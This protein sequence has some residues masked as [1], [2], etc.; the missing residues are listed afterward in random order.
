MKDAKKQ[1]VVVEEKQLKPVEKMPSKTDDGYLMF[2]SEK[3][4]AK[5]SQKLREMNGQQ[6]ELEKVLSEGQVSSCS[7]N[8]VGNG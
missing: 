2:N 1:A 6:T 4:N 3:V 7:G 8:S 5:A